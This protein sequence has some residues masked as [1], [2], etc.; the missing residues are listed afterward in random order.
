MAAEYIL[1][2][3]NERVMLCERG[4]RTFETA[5]RFTLDLMAVP[6]LK[7]LS[8][9]PVIVD[10]SHAAGRRDLVLPLSLAAAAAGAD[11]IIV[12]VHPRSR[13]GDL[14]RAA[15]AAAPTSS[16]TT[17][18]RVQARGRG[19]GQ[20]ARRPFEGRRRRRRADRRLDRRWPRA[21]ALGATVARLRPRPERRSSGALARGA[22]R[23]AGATD[24]RGGRPAPR[25]CSSPRRSARCR[26]RSARCSRRAR[27]T[28]WSPTSARP[29]ARSSAAHDDP[30]VRRRPPAGRRRDLGRRARARRPVRRRDLVP[31]AHGDRP[32]A[33]STSACTG[34]CTA[35]GAQPTAIDAETHD[36]IMATV[37]HLPHVLANV[38]VAQ[39]ARAL[40][41]RRRAPAGD[42]PELPRRHPR[43]RA[44]SAI[45]TDIYL[46]NRD[47]LAAEID[48]TIARLQAVRDALAAGRPRPRSPR[49]TTPPPPTA[50]AC[51]RRQLAGGPAVR[52][53]RVGAQPPGRGRPDRARARPRR[54]QHHRHGA[55]SRRRHER[56]RGRAV[57]RRRG[58]RR[59]RRRSSCA[60]LGFPVARRMNVAL[61]AGRALRGRD[62]AAGRQVDLAPRRDHRRDGVRAGRGSRNYLHAA[63]TDSTLAAVARARRDRR[64]ARRRELLIRG[65]GLRN[66]P[67]AGGP[68]STSATPAR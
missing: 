42:R 35:L 54:R 37:S 18:Q 31:D 53:A 68:R 3:G 41:R 21:S 64:A 9:L 12:E 46:S 24:R 22:H 55:V 52:A 33:S 13:G 23:R 63:D 59:A 20:G 61:R 11:G 1:K 27:R 38:L 45:W 32:P 30:R 47:A 58:S 43:R 19:R 56:G 8:H 2:E 57:D 66:A 44:P 67:A 51:S 60:G 6:V 65:C 34:C 26:R 25:R 15:A 48:D 36:R 4:I 14:R 49:G 29:S 62:R 28:A 50:G 16:P 40:G 5:Y 17:P 10:P 39:A 7:Q